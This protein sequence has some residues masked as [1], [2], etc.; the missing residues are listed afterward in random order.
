[1]CY[2]L[3]NY[4]SSEEIESYINRVGTRRTSEEFY[5]NVCRLLL[6]S[7]HYQFVNV[8]QP[9]QLYQTFVFFYFILA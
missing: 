8:L 6:P 7:G 1:M 3:R 9:H 4:Q 5:D 2:V